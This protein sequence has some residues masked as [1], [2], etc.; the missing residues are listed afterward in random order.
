MILANPE[1]PDIKTTVQAF[2]D[3]ETEQ[4]ETAGRVQ[5]DH[6][7]SLERGSPSSHTTVIFPALWL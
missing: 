6:G 1:C 4:G 5:P 2:G 3:S 7:V